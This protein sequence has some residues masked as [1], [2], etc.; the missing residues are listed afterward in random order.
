MTDLRSPDNERLEAQLR[1]RVGHAGLGTD[2]RERIVQSVMQS[3]ARRTWRRSWLAVLAPLAAVVVLVAVVAGLPVLLPGGLHPSNPPTAAPAPAQSGQPPAAS[4][5]AQGTRVLLDIELRELMTQVNAGNEQPTVVADASIAVATGT[6]LDRPDCG[7][8]GGCLIGTYAD[9]N[10]V[11]T[12]VYADSSFRDAL[13]AGRNGAPVSPDA[14]LGGTFA[15]HL[16][17]GNIDLLGDVSLTDAGGL[18][19]PASADGV[20]G[21][22]SSP[23]GNVVAVDGWLTLTSFPCAPLPDPTPPPDSPFDPCGN[24]WVS[25]HPLGAITST[26][27]SAI[28]VQRSAYDTFAPEHPAADLS[29]VSQRATYLIKLVH[30]P[31]STCGPLACLGWQMVGRLTTEGLPDAN[32]PSPPAEPPASPIAPPSAL[33]LDELKAAIDL[34]RAGGVGSRDVIADVAIDTSQKPAPTSRECQDPPTNCTVIGTISALGPDLGV[35]LLRDDLSTPPAL[36]DGT[37]P[38]PVA[39]HIEGNGLLEF[40]GTVATGSSALSWTVQDAMAAQASLPV[41]HV[42]A[43]H[44]WLVGMEAFSCG[45]APDASVPPVPPFDCGIHDYIT[46]DAEQV[47]FPYGG[48]GAEGRAPGDGMTV[49]MGAYQQF[50]PNPQPTDTVGV[51]PREGIYLVQ[52]VVNHSTWG[53]LGALGWLVVGR[54]DTVAATATPVP[55]PTPTPETS[56]GQQPIV[57]SAAEAEALIDAN[58]SSWT[59]RTLV[60]DGAVTPGAAVRCPGPDPCPIGTL[61]G[62]TEKVVASPATMPFVVSAADGGTSGLLAFTVRSDGLEYLGQ[63]GVAADNGIVFQTVDAA[64]PDELNGRPGRLLIV[65]G[66]LV[67]SGPLPCPASPPGPPTPPPDSPFEACPS[68][69]ISA[70]DAPVWTRGSDGSG[71]MQAPPNGIRVQW[72]AYQDFALDPQTALG[73]TGDVPRLGLYVLRLVSDPRPGADPATGWQVVARI[74]P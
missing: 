26:P 58:R 1:R 51:Q 61:D 62:T 70:S 54:V 27:I 11:V 18:L 17:A 63:V 38:G 19:W 4:A 35:V 66:W 39:L 41:D 36:P 64:R 28:R 2:E 25:D 73:G 15:L 8:S 20:K 46:P 13:V 43:V 30:D 74:D 34:A 45:P 72:T 10:G 40:L 60:V 49:Q 12:P 22:E 53:G 55:E 32:A 14:S 33:T 65:G 16:A 48:N 68:A 21:A 47:T 24:S 69:W 42:V 67:D 23:V 71:S 56:P 59:G 3:T 37:Q 29:Q 52:A 50:A 44:G 6:F 7:P 5:G 57:R 9:S 31:R